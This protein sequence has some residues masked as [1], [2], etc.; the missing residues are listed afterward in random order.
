MIDM[1]MYPCPSRKVPALQNKRHLTRDRVEQ[2]TERRLLLAQREELEA[3]RAHAARE[4]RRDLGLGAKRGEQPRQRGHEREADA[5]VQRGALRG[6]GGGAAGGAA[7]ALASG[8]VVRG[9]V[10]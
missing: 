5:L 7:A 1:R 4:R 6:G 2:A 8:L 9:P 10:M 3:Q